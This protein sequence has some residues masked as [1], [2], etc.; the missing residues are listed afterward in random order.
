MIVMKFGGSSVQD[1]TAIRRVASI[2]ASRLAEQPLV[3]VSAMGGVTDKLVQVAEAAARSELGTALGLLDGIRARHV[4]A[5]SEMLSP[6]AAAAFAEELEARL[7]EATALAAQIAAQGSVTPAQ[8]S[9]ML[10]FG[11][12]LSSVLVAAAFEALDWVG[13]VLTQHAV[14][15]PIVVILHQKAESAIR[16]EQQ[17]LVPTPPVRGVG[18]RLEAGDL[19]QRA[20][21]QAAHADGDGR[22]VCTTTYFLDQ[23][24]IRIADVQRAATGRADGGDADAVGADRDASAA[25]RAVQ[26]PRAGG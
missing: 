20:N 12:L 5:A 14:K 4:A 16:I 24:D 8:H 17:I 7:A 1:A 23:P 18:A 11:E 6:I 19:P 26:H 10:T 9:H 2:V 15:H 3:V 21:Q 25:R 22:F 13:Y